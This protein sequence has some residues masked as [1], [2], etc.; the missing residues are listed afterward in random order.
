MPYYIVDNLWKSQKIV[1]NYRKKVLMHM[2]ILIIIEEKK[3]RNGWKK[4]Y[5][6]R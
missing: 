5:I 4:E 6:H 3:G 1:D 2:F